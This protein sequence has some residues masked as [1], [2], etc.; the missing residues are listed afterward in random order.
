MCLPCIRR[1]RLGR[2][3]IPAWGLHLLYYLL[4][5]CVPWVVGLQY[6]DSLPPETWELAKNETDIEAL[7]VKFGGIIVDSQAT[8]AAFLPGWPEATYAVLLAMFGMLRMGVSEIKADP[9]RAREEE[10]ELMANRY[11]SNYIEE[12]AGRRADYHAAPEKGDWFHGPLTTIQIIIATLMSIAWTVSF[13]LTQLDRDTAGWNSVVGW[14][15]PLWIGLQMVKREYLSGYFV[16][17]FTAF[18]WGASLTTIIQ[19][20]LGTIGTVAYVIT[21]TNSC[22]PYSTLSFLTAGI[23]S[24]AFRIMQTT[25]FAYASSMIP[26]VITSALDVSDKDGVASKYMVTLLITCGPVVYEIIY[27]ALIASKGTPVVISGTC[28][29]VELSPRFGFFDSDIEFHWKLLMAITGL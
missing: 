24:R 14:G 2:P 5:T 9:A 21:N 20:W 12:H 23:R 11:Y 13:V 28:M 6:R 26:L 1:I 7:R 19:R 22:Q 29:L 27:M 18:Q 17:L 25:N 3:R 10:V 4:L 15:F 16:L 8:P